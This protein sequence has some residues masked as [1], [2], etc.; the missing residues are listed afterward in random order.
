VGAILP[1][2]SGG[3]FEPSDIQAMSLAYEGIC[4]ALHVNGDISVREAIAARVI[5][6]ARRG[7]R[8]P[9]VLRDRVLAE[10]NGDTGIVRLGVAAWGGKQPAP[11]EFA[12]GRC[13]TG[14]TILESELVGG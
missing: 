5:E 2:V 4:D 3:A 10:A 8:C 13:S 11:H 9:T 12:A 14:R 6:L 7:E 1:F